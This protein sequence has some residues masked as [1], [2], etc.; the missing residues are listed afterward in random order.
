MIILSGNLNCQEGH[1]KLA[2]IALLIPIEFLR[3]K[4]IGAISSAYDEFRIGLENGTNIKQIT[5]IA[6]S[7]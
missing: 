2:F 1:F 7:S 4:I 3:H 5:T 6:C